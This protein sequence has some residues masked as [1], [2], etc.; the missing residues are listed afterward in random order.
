MCQQICGRVMIEEF[1]FHL[2][3]REKGSF[4]WQVGLCALIWGFGREKKR[5]FRGVERNPS[6]AWS[7]VRFNVSLWALVTK[8]L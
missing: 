1:L 5:I 2:D 8:L 7:F 4:L 6:K 3:F